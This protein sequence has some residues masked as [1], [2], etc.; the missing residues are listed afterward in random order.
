M[1]FSNFYTPVHFN[2]LKLLRNKALNII[3]FILIIVP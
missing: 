3:I 1:Q 2:L